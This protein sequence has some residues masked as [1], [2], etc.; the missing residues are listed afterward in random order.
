MQRFLRPFVAALAL[1]CAPFI[2]SAQSCPNPDGPDN[3]GTYSA[4]GDQLFQPRQFS[5][6]AGGN[7][8]IT[9]CGNVRPQTDRGPGFVTTNPDFSFQLSGMNRYRLELSVVSA[10]DSILLINTGSVS[11]FYDDDDNPSSIGDP[12]IT[13][14]RPANGRIDV[15]VGTYDGA[16]CDATLTLET[17]YR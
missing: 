12:R 9:K 7:V 8:D 1:A 10:C 11:W 3:Y 15:W 5:L 17:F 16:F 4:T 2:A 13:L 14:S 6:Q